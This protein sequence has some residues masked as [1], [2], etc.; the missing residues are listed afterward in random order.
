PGETWNCV[1]VEIRVQN[2]T[3]LESNLLTQCIS[4][5]HGDAAL[6]LQPGAFWIDAQ[7]HLLRTDDSLD[8][9]APGV[10]VHGNFGHMSDVGTGI[11]PASHPVTTLTW[12]LGG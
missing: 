11:D 10:L 5:A 1:V 7:S 12:R 8:L 4:Q 3:A 9:D 6:H 2:L